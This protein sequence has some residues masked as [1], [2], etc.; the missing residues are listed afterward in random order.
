MTVTA[1][2]FLV[3]LKRRIT[4]PASQQL[5][6]DPDMLQMADDTIRDKLVPMLL[7]VNANF[8]VKTCLTL[9]V[10]E[11]K[12]YAIEARA[13]GRGLRDLKLLGLGSNPNTYSL[14][15]IALEDEHLFPAC[16]QPTGFYFSGD[17]IMLVPTPVS[18]NYYLKQFFNIQ[19]N[20]LVT[21]ASAARVVAVAGAVVTCVSV[22]ST[23]TAGAY[24]DF[25]QGVS[26]CSI[27][28]W[29]KLVTNVAGNNITF[30]ASSDIPSTLAAGDYVTMERQTPVLNLP[31][32]CQ[33]ILESLTGHKVLYAIG[34]Y[35]G[36]AAL[37]KDA[38]IQ[39]KN[40]LKILQPRIEGE[41][42]KIV[43]RNGLLRGRGFGNLR[44]RSGNL[45]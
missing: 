45:F 44:N 10:A 4:Q 28:A 8:F 35:E 43:N 21:V 6:T 32:E 14:S 22:P 30:A 38:D 23:F 11:Q 19:P 17:T 7:S 13:I 1:D 37:L 16:G 18:A 36:A 15:Q 41:P 29:S 40:L 26:G 2:R 24:C 9:L 27:L 25:V 5:M 3:G 39:E 12:E 42:Q 20:Q 34:D 33:Q 31:D